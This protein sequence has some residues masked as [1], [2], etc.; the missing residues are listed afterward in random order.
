MAPPDA[1]DFPPGEGWYGVGSG[2]DGYGETL[3]EL[4]GDAVSGTDTQLLCNAHDVAL[5]GAAAFAAGEGVPAEQGL[6]VYLR[7]QVAWKK[8]GA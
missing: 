1:L 8:T 4:L 6:P 5:L 2:W 7:D 3:A